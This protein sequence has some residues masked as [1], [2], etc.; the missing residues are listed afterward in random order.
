[1]SRRLALSCVLL[2]LLALL[3]GLALRKRSPRSTEPD[4]DRS[5]ATSTAATPEPDGVRGAG[6]SATASPAGPRQSPAATA[7]NRTS[8]IHGRVTDALSGAPIGGADVWLSGRDRLLEARTAADGEWTI[9]VDP[10]KYEI[11]VFAEGYVSSRAHEAAGRARERLSKTPDPNPS[12]EPGWQVTAGEGQDVRLDAALHPAAELRGSVGDPEGR[13]IAGAR[14]EIFRHSLMGKGVGT[15]LT[16]P[17]QSPDLSRAVSD[18]SGRFRLGRLYPEGRLDVLVSAPGFATRKLTVELGLST[19]DLRVTLQRAQPVT[20]VVLDPRGAPVA[21]AVVFLHDTLR[22]HPRW[23][24]TDEAGRFRFDDPPEGASWVA[25]W[26]GGTAWTAARPGGE[27]LRLFLPD[28]GTEVIGV[29]RDE[30]GA[31]LEGAFVGV[32]HVRR[33]RGDPT[34]VLVPG[35]EAG[36]SYSVSSDEAVVQVPLD[37][38]DLLSR[39]TDLQGEFRLDDMCFAEDGAVR[40]VIA[41]D[42]FRTR[43]L[44][45]LG[46]GR[47][48]VTLRRGRADDEDLEGLIEERR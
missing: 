43:R 17:Q 5:D 34:G 35:C 44:D 14:V 29:V 37:F 4:R 24:R 2:I 13:P 6:W 27:A 10:A 21:R 12:V 22:A 15:L 31:L 40:L 36:S 3:A 20:G 9:F 18:D 8:R 42:G 25:A 30:T 33:R 45:V 23:E 39:T 1:M 26:N 16:Y 11:N 28:R 47:L 19:P 48:D 7:A 38:P 41:K 32:D 46:P